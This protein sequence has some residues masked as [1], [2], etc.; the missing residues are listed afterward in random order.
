MNEEERRK[1]NFRDN[2]SPDQRFP[3]LIEQCKDIPWKC[4]ACDFILGWVDKETKSQVRI[5]SKDHWLQVQGSIL[6]VCRR[7][8]KLNE[9]MDSDFSEFLIHKEEFLKWLVKKKQEAEK[10]R[11]IK[12]KEIKNVK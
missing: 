12:K 9:L 2:R 8:G 7:C 6:H 10:S 3:Q 11:E 4:M 1:R 5:K